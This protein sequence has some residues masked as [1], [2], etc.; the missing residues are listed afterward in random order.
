MQK[1]IAIAENSLE[2]AGTRINT[3][4]AAVRLAEHVDPT[5]MSTTTRAMEAIFHNPAYSPI[6]QR[7]LSWTIGLSRIHLAAD[8][9]HLRAAA[10]AGAAQI[11]RGARLTHN[12]TMPSDAELVTRLTAGAA[13]LLATDDE[14]NRRAAASALFDLVE[15]GDAPREMLQHFS[16]IEIA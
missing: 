2:G 16:G 9:K 10:L 4:A 14:R 8:Q 5:T 13:E 6:D 3:I 12:E 1:L 7:A 11:Y 15:S